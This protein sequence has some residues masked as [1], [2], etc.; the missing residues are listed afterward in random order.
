MAEHYSEAKRPKF[1]PNMKSDVYDVEYEASDHKIT[2]PIIA[3]AIKDKGDMDLAKL[4][5]EITLSRATL[6][7]TKYT[8]SSD[9][10]KLTEER[11]TALVKGGEDI[12]SYGLG[13]YDKSHVK[14]YW[15]AVEAI[16]ENWD[17]FDRTELG[18]GEHRE[19]L[20]ACWLKARNCWY[21]MRVEK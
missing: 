7:V 8:Q 18:E 17:H 14:D 2:H 5:C 4:Q 16:L 1:T 11:Y 19:M 20:I 3:K 10:G 12:A 9:V 13:A 6:G 21:M 15:K